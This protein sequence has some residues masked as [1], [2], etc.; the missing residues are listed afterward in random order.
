MSSTYANVRYASASTKS[1][2]RSRTIVSRLSPKLKN[3]STYRPVTSTL[4]PVWL[5]PLES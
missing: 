2:D 4:T 5:L 3:W 1:D